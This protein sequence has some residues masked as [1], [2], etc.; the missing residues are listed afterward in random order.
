MHAPLQT[1]PEESKPDVPTRF[2][3]RES[4][5]GCGLPLF[6][7]TKLNVNQ[8]GDAFEQEA[9]HVARAA[10]GQSHS[11]P[12]CG[13]SGHKC[14]TCEAAEHKVQL[15]RLPGVGAVGASPAINTSGGSPLSPTV[16]GRVE[17]L[18]GYD[19]GHV[20]VHNDSHAGESAAALQA[21]AF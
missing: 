4:G 16:R 20:R 10:T 8:P 5:A 7:Q 6:L 19:L 15:K 3:A 17:P 18:L 21:K 11:C 2:S 1:R 12:T 13:G 14:P 9:D